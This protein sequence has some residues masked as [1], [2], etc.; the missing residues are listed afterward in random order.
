MLR[1]YLGAQLAEVNPSI[2]EIVC[3]F[4]GERLAAVPAIR[5]DSTIIHAQKADRAGNVL[6]EGITGVQKEA[7]LAAKRALV[8]VEEIVD[9]LRAPSPNS[10]ILPSWTI[11]VIALAPHGAHPSYAYGYYPRD[12]AFYQAWDDIARDRAT[13]REWMQSNVLDVS[14]SA[15]AKNGAR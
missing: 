4:T 3:P 8:T 12:N 13:F 6:L 5:P 7:V 15:A 14:A 10:T 2:R 11:D 1:G 9:D